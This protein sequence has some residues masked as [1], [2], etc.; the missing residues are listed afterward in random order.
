MK[1]TIVSIFA[2]AALLTACSEPDNTII[3][4]EGEVIST[5]TA[6]AESNA[7]LDKELSGF[8]KEEAMRAKEKAENITTLKFDKVLHDFGEVESEVKNTTSFIV[9]NTGNKP[10][11]ISDVSTTCGCT[12][13]KKPEGPI[14]PGASDEIQVTFKS[15]PTQKN[16][17]KKTITITANTAERVHKV[18]IRAF[19]K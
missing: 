15:K 18:D 8:E 16:E 1:K 14:A 5:V 13:P 6:D 11:I 17:I 12:T 3:S 2:L 10:L 7:K 4:M 9:T 19:V